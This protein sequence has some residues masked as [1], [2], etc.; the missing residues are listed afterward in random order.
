MRTI[1]VNRGSLSLGQVSEQEVSNGLGSGKFLPD[2]LGWTEGMETWQ[3]LSTFA[4]LPPP[5]ALAASPGTP[6]PLGAVPAGFEQPG[7]IR[8]DECLKTAWECFKVNWGICIVGTLIFFG[9]SGVVQMPMQLA[10]P[11]LQH[12]VKQGTPPPLWLMICGGALFFLFWVVS[13]GISSILPAGF[14]YFFIET[15]R[16][17]KGKIE[18]LF[19]G[20]RGM[21]WVQLL[22]AMLVW[23]VAFI[24]VGAVLIAPGVYFSVTMKSKVPAIVAGLLLL[25]PFLYF[26]VGIGFVFPL[27]VDRKIGFWE[28]MVTAFQTVHHQWFQT[29]GL[30]ILICLVM[31]AGALV[32]CVGLLASLPLAYLIYAQG[33]RQLFGDRA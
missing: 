8:Y 4:N 7:K 22:L 11:L 27:I 14:L 23:I 31:L 17:G 26:S 9:I 20:F 25:I 12:F 6:P 29:F 21:N 28:A 32:C 30:W 15:L 10:Q 1:F 2:D 18:H 16:T 5:I 24:V 33:Y 13:M 19:A 3:P